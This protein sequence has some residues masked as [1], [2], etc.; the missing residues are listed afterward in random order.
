MGCRLLRKSCERMDKVLSWMLLIIT[1]WSSGWIP[2]LALLVLRKRE[3]PVYPEFLCIDCQDKMKCNRCSNHLNTMKWTVRS[4]FG[5]TALI[6]LTQMTGV[7]RVVFVFFLFALILISLIDIWSKLIPNVITLPMACICLFLRLFVHPS[8]VLN[9]VLTSVA[10]LVILFLIGWISKAM[11]GGDAKF[12]A[13]CGLVVGW[14]YIL[15]AFWIATMSAL[16]FMGM[17]GFGQNKATPFGPHLSIGSYVSYLWGDP[18]I[19]W[20]VDSISLY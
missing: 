15:L 12:F 18:L 6:G 19:K 14:P 9:Y 2:S 5:I 8:P 10:T 1:A 7:E 11:G 20:Y 16:L 3:E 13:V 17:K 4:I